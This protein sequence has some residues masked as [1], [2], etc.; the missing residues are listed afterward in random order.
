MHTKA[1]Q[2]RF[3][4]TWS[5]FRGSPSSRRASAGMISPSLTLMMSPGT[6]IADSSSFHWPFLRTFYHN[7]PKSVSPGNDCVAITQQTKSFQHCT[8]ALGARRAM[9]A[10]AALPALFSSM[11][12]I[13]ELMM[14]KVM[15]PTKSCQS[16]GF[17]WKVQE[18]HP[19]NPLNPQ[20]QPSTG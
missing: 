15:I 10:A 11:K 8:L 20:F 6:R 16:G 18:E 5:I 12:L 14:S 9:R 2:L 4:M 1:E 7:K 19:S 3:A 13:V 17:P